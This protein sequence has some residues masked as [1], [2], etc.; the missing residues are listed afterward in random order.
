MKN[1]TG[2]KWA[3]WKRTK[4]DKLHPSGDGRCQKIIKIPALPAA[5]FWPSYNGSSPPIAKRGIHQP[6]P[7]SQ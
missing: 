7:R 4:T 1:C 6:S 3:K 2:C 5:F